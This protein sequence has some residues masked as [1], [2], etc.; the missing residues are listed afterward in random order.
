M[1]HY[2][3]LPPEDPR[4]IST[5]HQYYKR[6]VKNGFM[7]RYDIEDDFGQ[8][9]N[10]FIVCTF[11]MVNALFIIGEREK[12]QKMFDHMLKYRNHLGL[13]SE[14]IEVCTGRLTGNFPKSYSHLALI[15]SAF[16]LE[17]EYNWL[18]EDQSFKMI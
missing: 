3:F 18:D 16:N 6:L 12:A 1:L 2:N 15:Q 5:V 7:F 13:L 4:I 9:E 10:A 8:P 14:D 11:W 17:T